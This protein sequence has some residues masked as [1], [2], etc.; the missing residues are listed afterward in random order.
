MYIEQIRLENPNRLLLNT[1]KTIIIRPKNRIQIIVG[2]NGSG[3]SFLLS[4]INLM[5]PQPRF[6]GKNGVKEITLRHLGH[7]YV[8][9]SELNPTSHYFIKDGVNLNDGRT[10]AV[11]KDLVFQEFGITQFIHELLS[12]ETTFT[13]LPVAKRREAFTLMSRTDYDY[14]FW[15]HKQLKTLSRDL[16]GAY[17][18]AQQKLTTA[19]GVSIDLDEI[20]N[21]KALISKEEDNLNY[22]EPFKRP[23]PEVNIYELEQRQ[24]ELVRLSQEKDNLLEEAYTY[25][26]LKRLNPNQ[27]HYMDILVN[28]KNELAKVTGALGVVKTEL[29]N[30]NTQLSKI[31]TRNPEELNKIAERQEHLKE[32]IQ[33][34]KSKV[35]TQLKFGNIRKTY[36][37]ALWLHDVLT[38]ILD[39]PVFHEGLSTVSLNTI[40]TEYQDRMAKQT[41]LSQGLH[42]AREELK[43]LLSIKTQTNITCPQCSFAFNTEYSESKVEALSK[44]IEVDTEALNIEA[45]T[46]KYLWIKLAD[47]QEYQ[48]TVTWLKDTIYSKYELAEFW[49]GID[50]LAIVKKNPPEILN[51]VSKLIK[52]LQLLNELEPLEAEYQ[53]NLSALNQGD[54]S[55]LINN[56]QE[57]HHVLSSSMEE[58]LE[59]RT[60]LM[61]RLTET[62]KLHARVKQLS[63][64][65]NDISNYKNEYENNHKVLLEY[66]FAITINDII[67][68]CRVRLGKY[69]SSM[70]SLTNQREY[71]DTLKAEVE[72]LAFQ[73]EASKRLVKELSPNEGL[74][75]ET[76]YSVLKN[77]ISQMNQGIKRIAS[78]DIA[79]SL[80]KTEEL[81]YM[82]PVSIK[83]QEPSDDIKQTSRGQE[84]IINLIFQ[85][86]FADFLNLKSYRM[87]LDEF[88]ASFDEH[89]KS[90]VTDIIKLLVEDEQD[91]QLFLVSHDPQIYNA[92]P[93]ADIFVLH[94]DNIVLPDRPFNEHVEM[95]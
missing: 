40:E 78:Y 12:G 31:E 56:L 68:Q 87:S 41:R 55:D 90:K 73:I 54:Q 79:I 95:Y 53:L 36:D 63:T 25:V 5:P 19:E 34:I 77:F 7:T 20:D 89:H 11:Q 24:L 8:L 6:Y 92:L 83:G 28:I 93:N 91:T 43:H 88:G 81:D 29:S 57:R 64:L 32:R 61:T 33:D 76:L 10:A 47:I 49:S 86:V 71:V 42:K 9:R 72:D 67:N 69:S 22:V 94:A 3:K 46:S 21:L 65:E 75:A 27:E 44:Q 45:A 59:T 23:V 26:K 48:K 13:D 4:Q 82:F 37:S 66:D 52:D 60:V 16:E 80:A 62:Q 70:L 74:I 35:S 30:I 39:L 15:L 2:T 38:P 18:L 14:A 51:L 50:Y 85:R 58:H 84:E 1:E 17:K